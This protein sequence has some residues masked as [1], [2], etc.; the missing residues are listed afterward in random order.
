MQIANPRQE[1]R[2]GDRVGDACDNCP[3]V[4]NVLQTDTDGDGIGDACETDEDNDGKY[5]DGDVRV[6]TCKRGESQDGIVNNT[7][8]TKF[9]FN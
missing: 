5:C 6:P 7:D 3:D 1:D 9:F 8:L 2:D 4:S